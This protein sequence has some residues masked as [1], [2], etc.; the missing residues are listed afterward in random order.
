MPSAASVTSARN[1]EEKYHSGVNPQYTPNECYYNIL[2][3]WKIVA[4]TTLEQREKQHLAKYYSTE[5][6]KECGKVP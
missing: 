5:L 3:N 6:R 2:S 4:F 1:A